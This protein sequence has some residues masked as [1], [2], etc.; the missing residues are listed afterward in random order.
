MK[1]ALQ[2]LRAY[3]ASYCHFAE[4]EITVPLSMW[5]AGTYMFEVFDSY[6][7]LVINARVKRAGKT[8]LSE[9]IGFTS[10]MPF[11]VSGASAPALFRKISDDKPTIIW[12]EAETLSSESN[13]LVR[14]FLNVGYRKGQTIPRATGTGVVEWPTY[15]PKTFVLI[16]DVYDTLRDRSI[17]CEMQRG[18]PGKRFLYEAAKEEGLEIADELRGV[19]EQNLEAIVSAYSTLDLPF[20][21]DRDEEIW[22]PIFAICS[23]IDKESMP[24]LTRIAADLAAEKTNPYRYEPDH[25]AEAQAATEEYGKR[26]LRDT[27]TVIA[28]IKPNGKEGDKRSKFHRY[29]ATADLIAAL[30]AIPTAPW[31]KFYSVQQNGVQGQESKKEPGI[32]PHQIGDFF[33]QFGIHPKLVRN[34][35]DVFRGYDCDVIESIAKKIKVAV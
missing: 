21:T 9:L 1:T 33:G 24:A 31:R 2:Q 14:A 30:K 7:Y 28:H 15:C 4:P 11:N 3:L 6:P 29:I 26:L 16:G 13:S 20:L 5:V 8:R 19:L 17:I 32:T 25:N 35:K 10:N 23:V 22:R 12:D 27:L 18:E 34:G